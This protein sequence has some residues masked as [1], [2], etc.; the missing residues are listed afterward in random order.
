[1][2]RNWHIRLEA[3]LAACAFVLALAG[4]SRVGA[5]TAV[6]PQHGS[7][8]PTRIESAAS[9]EVAVT[10]APG[11]DPY[12]VAESYGATIVRA[13]WSG[14]L[15]LRPAKGETAASLAQRMSGD[16]R[17]RTAEV[18]GYLET[19]ESRQQSWAFDDGMGSFESFKSQDA[20][21]VLNLRAAH[22]IAL[23]R[24]VKV[25]I[26]DTG[27]ET[28]HPTLSWRIMP[29]GYDYI[30][31]DYDAGDSADNVD[32]D[33]DGRIDEAR[34]HGTHVAGLVSLVAPE[35]RLLP[36]RVLDADGRG[37][38]VSVAAGIYLA[39]QRGVNVINMSLGSL[40]GSDM[41]ELALEEAEEAGIVCV[42]SA[43]NWGSENPREFPAR[44]SHVLAIAAVD[45]EKRPAEFSSYGH[46]VAMSAPG[47]ALRSTYIDGSY[48]LWSGTSMS[49]P[50]ISG[51]VALLLELHPDWTR[52]DVAQ[53]IG[54]TASALNDCT[55]L[56]EM[57][58]RGVID[59]GAALAPDRDLA[60]SGGDTELIDPR[61]P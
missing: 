56:E 50:L 15:A 5:P 49:A 1:M 11:V 6:D 34:G 16:P 30:D 14:C 3:G 40:N 46:H 20:T 39:I 21:R 10:L 53:R 4:C 57:F 12:W 25:A 2:E 33:G 37:D 13:P 32:N 28:T 60:I 7:S 47:V 24:T 44:S 55:A 42:S 27:I 18:N 52:A 41:V 26:L 58:G 48:V 61:R 38:M 17:L 36:V 22:P 59:A 43:G 54:D 29:G 31:A 51:S 19:A 45:D 8:Y 35:A 23:G 9:V